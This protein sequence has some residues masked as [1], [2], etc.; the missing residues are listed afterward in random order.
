MKAAGFI[1]RVI[2]SG[3]TAAIT[4]AIVAAV[5]SRLERGRADAAAQRGQPHRFGGGP[6]PA[7]AGPAGI[8]LVDWCRA[9][10]RRCG[11]SGRRRSSSL[12]GRIARRSARGGRASA[13]RSSRP[14]PSS[15]TITWCRAGSA[16]ATKR[17]C[18]GRGLFA[19]YAA[20][21]A[22]LALGARLTRLDDHEPENRDE[23]DK[24]G[25][26]EDGP[27]RVIAPERRPVAPGRQPRPRAR[28][29]AMRIC[30]PDDREP[31]RALRARRA[32]SMPIARSPTEVGRR[33]ARDRSRSLV[34][35][36]RWGW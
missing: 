3:G 34:G 5:C 36:W 31:A 13:A 10:R 23:R 22:G 12:F 29:L 7:E 19:L 35:G 6:P 15:P 4:S 30:I 1:G 9:P 8:N 25:D 27:D 17:S 20:L 16:P 26:A 33:D 21:A 11:S 32:Q 2:V 24:G 14:S 28:A 18:R